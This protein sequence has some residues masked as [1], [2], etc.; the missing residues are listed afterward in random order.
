[1][2]FEVNHFAEAPGLKDGLRGEDVA[3]PSAILE[4]REKPILLVGDANEFAG[5][6][7]IESEGLIDDDVLAGAKGGSREREVAVVRGGDDDEVEVR[8]CR[9]LFCGVDPDIWEF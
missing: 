9:R 6:G 3:L 8:V 4:D 7:E 5:F 2:G 1:V